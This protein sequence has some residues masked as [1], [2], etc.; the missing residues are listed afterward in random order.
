MSG[1]NA[2]MAVQGVSDGPSNEE[3]VQPMIYLVM[4]PGRLMGW[5]CWNTL[6]GFAAMQGIKHWLCFQRMNWQVVGTIPVSCALYNA[7]VNWRKTCFFVWMPMQIVSRKVGQYNWIWMASW[8]KSW[9]QL[10]DTVT[11]HSLTCSTSNQLK[12]EVPI[13]PTTTVS[14]NIVVPGSAIYWPKLRA[15]QSPTQQLAMAT[16]DAPISLSMWFHSLHCL[17]NDDEIGLDEEF[18]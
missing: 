2:M 11:S 5:N 8:G 15:W 16:E 7:R 9:Q 12:T 14:Y 13:V 17:P 10:V 3:L 6:W 18:S 4:I 1:A